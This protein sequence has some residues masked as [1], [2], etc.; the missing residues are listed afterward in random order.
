MGD[1]AHFGGIEGALG[2]CFA[3]NHKRH[4]GTPVFRT[5][6]SRSSPALTWESPHHRRRWVKPSRLIASP[7][8]FYAIEQRQTMRFTGDQLFG[9]IIDGHS[10]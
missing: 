10:E 4:G 8:D 9:P 6:F 1:G 5:A 7:T 2:F 3:G